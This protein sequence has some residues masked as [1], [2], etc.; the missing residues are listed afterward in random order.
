MAEAAIYHPIPPASK[1]AWLKPAVFVAGLWPVVLVAYRWHANT[2]DPEKVSDVLNKAGLMAIVFLVSSLA[3]TPLKITFGWT[4]P[5]RVR[6]MLGL[7]AFFY[8]FLHFS[9]YLFDK[10][11]SYQVDPS[12]GFPELV[13]TDVF[14]RKFIFVGFAAFVILIPLAITSTQ[15]MVRRLGARR[16]QMLHKLAYAAGILGVIHFLWKVKKDISEPMVYIAILSVLLAIRVS[17]FMRKRQAK[18]EA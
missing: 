16:W 3:C 17:N 18:R 7:F 4:W 2:L 11:Q 1:L 14:K 9:T 5:L 12:H 15:G 13:L 6:K 8:A 10:F